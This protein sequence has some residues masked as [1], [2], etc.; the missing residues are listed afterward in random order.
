MYFGTTRKGGSKMFIFQLINVQNRIVVVLL[1]HLWTPSNH[2]RNST[3]NLQ[4]TE[5]TIDGD[6]VRSSLNP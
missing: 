2:Y 3:G 5:P 4:F 1:Y 6:T